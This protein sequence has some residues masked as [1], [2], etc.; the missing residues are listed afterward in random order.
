MRG[1]ACHPCYQGRGALLPHHF[2]LTRLRPRPIRASGYGAA[3][4]FLCHYSVGLPRPGVTR[5]TALVEFG[6]SSP[7]PGSTRVPLLRRAH[8]RPVAGSDRLAR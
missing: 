4:Y 6:L 7:A 5:R 1:F 3:V 8:T 2:T